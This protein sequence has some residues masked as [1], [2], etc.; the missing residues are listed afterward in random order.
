[1]AVAQTMDF[2]AKIQILHKNG[3]FLVL[4]KNL[5]RERPP[6]NSEKGAVRYGWASGASK[7]TLFECK[8][9]ILETLVSTK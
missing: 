5:S 1:M 7:T 6:R 3:F 8:N 4:N 2:W 9:Q